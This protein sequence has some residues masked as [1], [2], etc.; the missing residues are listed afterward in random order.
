MNSTTGQQTTEQSHVCRFCQAVTTTGVLCDH[1]QPETCLD[2]PASHVYFN[3]EDR[4]W[5]CSHGCSY[6]IDEYIQKRL[7]TVILNA[8]PA[9]TL[10]YAGKRVEVII[11]EGTPVTP[12]RTRSAAE[13]VD[14]GCILTTHYTPDADALV[15]NGVTYPQPETARETPE[16]FHGTV[17]ED[18]LYAWPH[19]PGYTATEFSWDRHDLVFLE[20]PTDDVRISSYRFL[21]VV[22]DRDDPYTVPVEKY[23]PE[24]TFTPAQLYDA[25]NTYNRPCRPQDL[26]IA[27]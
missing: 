26:L 25:C 6:T 4:Q 15:T 22:T 13:P 27:P 24:L 20:V 7:F 5:H 8:P 2:C 16:R 10:S 9:E 14:D 3:T 21:N 19:T 18:A 1:C 12:Y 11:P 17:R 23:D